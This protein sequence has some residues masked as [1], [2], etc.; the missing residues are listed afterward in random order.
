MLYVSR[1]KALSRVDTTVFL[2]AR[3]SRWYYRWQRG[4]AIGSIL[5][6]PWRIA[7]V[8]LEGNMQTL[9]GSMRK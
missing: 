9:Q 2:A 7:D 3:F 8:H 4:I 6:F 5:S 1:F